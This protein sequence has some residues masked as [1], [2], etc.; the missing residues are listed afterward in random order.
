MKY[1]RFLRHPN[2]INRLLV[3]LMLSL[4]LGLFATN[5][6]L[7]VLGFGLVGLGLLLIVLSAAELDQLFWKSELEWWDDDDARFDDWQRGI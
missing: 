6:I 4:A 1:R 2:A 7:K 5:V 3:V